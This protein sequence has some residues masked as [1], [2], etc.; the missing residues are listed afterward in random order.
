MDFVDFEGFDFLDVEIGP[1]FEVVAE[2]VEDGVRVGALGLVVVAGGEEFAVRN[3]AVQGGL[4]GEHHPA[5]NAELY[6]AGE[7]AGAAAFAH[8]EEHDAGVHVV[9]AEEPVIVVEPAAVD[10]ENAGG[11]DAGEVGVV[12]FAEVGAADDVV[13]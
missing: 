3:S 13:I 2:V 10:V 9:L 1:E 12:E 7:H 8:V 6:G 11:F 4:V 5:L